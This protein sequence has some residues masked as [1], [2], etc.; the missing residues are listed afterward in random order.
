MKNQLEMITEWLE[1]EREI[2]NIKRILE[3]NPE[4]KLFR[5]KLQE[6]QE[7]RKIICKEWEE[8]KNEETRKYGISRLGECPPRKERNAESQRFE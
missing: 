8:L 1:N 3:R 5:I 2:R 6:H 7:K 4:D